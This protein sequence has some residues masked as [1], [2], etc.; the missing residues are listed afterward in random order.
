M[1]QVFTVL[2]L[3]VLLGLV[4]L[5]AVAGRARGRSAA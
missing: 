1:A 5:E 4:V 3:S 2:V